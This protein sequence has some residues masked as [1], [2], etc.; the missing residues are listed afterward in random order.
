MSNY[1][2]ATATLDHTMDLNL[3]N[4]L[5]S[6]EHLTFHSSNDILAISCAMYRL[7]CDMT[8]INFQGLSSPALAEQVIDA[9]FQMARL[10]R[11]YYSKK[12]MNL[13][14]KDINLTPYR[15]SLA[16]FLQSDGRTFTEDYIGL[17][18]KL[19]Q[20]WEYDTSIDQMMMENNVL[21][22]SRTAFESPHRPLDLRLT[23]TPMKQL[24]RITRRA[25][26]FQ[27]WF[28][29]DL[30][31]AVCIPVEKNNNLLHL[32]ETI[33]NISK[34]ISVSGYFDYRNHSDFGFLYPTKWK[35]ENN[36]MVDNI[37]N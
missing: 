20:F 13:A 1:Q 8:G 14:L 10:I 16:I 26:H 36:L 29:S 25:K 3:I 28:K 4:I 18:T 31:V 33:F 2:T 23:L 9:D 12:L 15:K 11:E 19:P 37:D 21:S 5:K 6:K 27:Y 24:S 17:I 30:N 32:W 7:E 35:L 22:L 34:S